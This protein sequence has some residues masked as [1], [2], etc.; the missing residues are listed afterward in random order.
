MTDSPA[1][2]PSAEPPSSAEPPT[3]PNMVPA[4]PPPPAEPPTILAAI[5][6]PPAPPTVLAAIGAQEADLACPSC[7]AAVWPGDNFCEVCR[8]EL[9][10]AVFSGAKPEQSA[11]CPDC[12]GAGVTPEGYCE[13]CGRKV[14]DGSDHSELELDLLAGITD[15]GLRHPRNED[16]MALAST[17]APGGEPMALAVVCDGV[18]TSSRADEA[19]HRAAKTAM[20]AL[21]SG[22]RTS[23]DLERA[24]TDAFMAAREALIAMAEEDP[25][26]QNA[27]SATFVSAIITGQKITICWLGDSRAYWLD[28]SG[29][30]EARQLS[31]DDSVAQEL[32]ARG[33]LS[34]PDALA[35]PAGHVITGW[36]GADLREA[37]PHVATF[38]PGARGALLLCSDGLWNYQPEATE[39][40]KMALPAALTNPLG[41]AA[42]LV[43]FAL[44]SGGSDN[45]T[46]VLVP[47][48][49][50]DSPAAQATA[51]L[52]ADTR[53]TLPRAAVAQGAV[54][55]AAFP[56]TDTVDVDVP[57]TEENPA[58]EH[59]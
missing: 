36:V 46:V 6:E 59:R 44:D 42:E 43:K 4:M 21:L 12:P 31:Q 20:E 37:Q 35:S 48:P 24:S 1:S 25:A 15:R 32:I 8:T 49:L 19:S 54:I 28:A 56:R 33:L 57:P 17:Q 50:G 34:A 26:A 55:S 18:S 47:F 58:D 53:V 30:A 10:P 13:S 38:A 27:P 9:A 40:A 41:S 39:L 52:Q 23:S 11:H 5:P 2:T 7:G 51:G 22:V 45:V 3:V 16:A 14:P 29:D